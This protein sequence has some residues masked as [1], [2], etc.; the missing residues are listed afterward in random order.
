M[1]RDVEKYD[2]GEYLCR[3]QNM[4]GTR[5]S[6]VARLSVYSEFKYHQN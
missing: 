2:A 3:A 4:V 1:I 6:D 5:D